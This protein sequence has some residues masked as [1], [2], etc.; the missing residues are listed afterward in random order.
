MKGLVLSGG[1][2]T[3]LRPLTHTSAKQLIPVA[4]KPVLFYALE[5]VRECGITDVGIIV[6]HTKNEVKAA[7]G[8]GS[9]F[10]IEVTYIEQDTPGGLAHAVLTAKNFL[11]NDPFVMYLGDN[12]LKE[13]IV[14]L[15]NKFKSS[16]CES[17]IAVCKVE[18][19]QR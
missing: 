15:C 1:T 19:P 18:N 13:G 14:D 6:G 7:V 10:N 16:K 17:L 8:N 11:K 12:I 2:G 3:R 5:D 9:K 4:N